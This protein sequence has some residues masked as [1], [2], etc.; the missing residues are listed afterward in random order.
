[1]NSELFTLNIRKTQKETFITRDIQ[2]Y[3]YPN[4]K[5]ADKS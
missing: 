3:L 1:M 5:P 2:K 4:K